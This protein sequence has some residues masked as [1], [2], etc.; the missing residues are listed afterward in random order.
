LLQHFF[1]FKEGAESLAFDVALHLGTLMAVVFF[2]RHDL[3]RMA[4]LK[5]REARRLLILLIVATLPAVVVGLFF[6]SDVE[7]MFV[8]PLANG[9]ELIFTGCV[10][11][12]TLW[13]DG[14]EK[15]EKDASFLSAF[16]IGVAQAVALL[17]GVSRSGITIAAAL[18]CGYRRDF[19]A[20][21]AFLMSIPAILGAVVLESPDIAHLDPHLFPQVILGVTVSAVV[22]FLSIRWLLG[23]ISRGRLYL[24]AYYCWAIGFLAL[25]T[26]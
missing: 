20:R 16:L 25:L 21:F 14:G 22:G 12:L 4:L 18:F 26:V 11:L 3:V 10:L 5:T 23:V 19:A 8:S 24:F 13:M 6:K 2:Y 9:F 1:G 7:T 15:T 17:P